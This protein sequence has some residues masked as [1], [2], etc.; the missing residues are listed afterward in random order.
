MEDISCSDEAVTHI[1]ATVVCCTLQ[2]V[3]LQRTHSFVKMY[4]SMSAE[5]MSV[6]TVNTAVHE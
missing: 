6:V 3:S 5:I 2:S 1:L 4:F